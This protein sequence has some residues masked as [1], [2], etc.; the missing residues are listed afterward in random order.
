MAGEERPVVLWEPQSRGAREY[1]S[2][3]DEVIARGNN[4]YK[5]EV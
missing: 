1:E 3:T 5:P 4:R 2:L